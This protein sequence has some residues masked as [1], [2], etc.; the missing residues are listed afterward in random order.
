MLGL[1]LREEFRGARLRG[2]TIDFTNDAKTGALDMEAKDFLA[3]TY[4]SIDL[5]KSI[6]AV[7]PGSNRTVVLVGNRGQGKSHLMAALCHMLN[8]PIAGEAWLGAWAGRIGQPVLAGLSLRSKLHVIAEPLHEQ[9]FP[10]LW[11]ILFARHPKGE[12][13]KGKWQGMKTAVPG[14]DI[15]V[16]MFKQQPTA[17]LLDEFQTWF[18]GLN[19]A[20]EPRQVWAF[21]F[22]QLLS[23]IAETNPE[24]LALVVSVR[25][26]NSNAAQQLFR[27]NPVRVDFKGEQAQQDRRRLLLYRIFE[28]RIN[29]PSAQIDPIVATHLSEFMRLTGKSGSEMDR[30]KARFVE[31]WP[32]SPE[33]MQLLDDEVIFAVQA[34]GTRDL[35]RILVEL[36]KTAGEKVPVI[37]PADFD[38]SGD[39][40]GSAASLIDT[41]G[42]DHH[43]QLRDK[44][45]RNL[46]AVEE[47][48]GS[49]LSQVPHLR[50]IVSALWLRSLSLDN[51][52]VGAEPENL[53]ID[54]TRASKVD[55]NAFQVELQAIENNSYNIHKLG[56]RLMFKLEENARTRLLA[57]ARNDKIFQN[58]EDV[59][60]LATEIR[61]AIGGDAQVSGLYR[62]VVLKR[63]WNSTPWD[64]LEERERP[65]AWDGRIPVIVLPASPEFL[66]ATLGKWLMKFLS[67]ARNTP[68]F[69]LPRKGFEGTI[70]Q[71]RELM[72]LARAACLAKEWAKT[73]AAYRSLLVEFNNQIKAKIA[74]RFDRFAVLRTWNAE[75]ASKCSFDVEPHSSRGDKIPLAIQEKIK[76]NL[77]VAEEFDEMVVSL[78]QSNRSLAYLL[79]ELREP[80]GGGKECIP[81]LG[82][83]EAK[84]AVLAVCADGRVAVNVRGLRSLQR[85]PGEDAEIALRRMK[86]DFD[87]SGKQLENTLLTLPG[88]P[89]SSAGQPTAGDLTASG[90]TQTLPGIPES[91]TPTVQSGN[92]FEQVSPGGSPFSPVPAP[93]TTKLSSHPTSG[94]NLLSQVADTWCIGPAT[95]VR[96]VSIRIDKL[97]GAQLQQLIK[98]LPD[99]VVYGLDVDKEDA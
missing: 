10:Y 11:D 97:T 5:I 14:K 57:H 37:T 19:N 26:G 43:K 32:Y 89:P 24:L 75:D 59:D 73:E 74:D 22:I 25:E 52:R 4:P 1:Q 94:L 44:A 40:R 55:D 9:R 7:A 60:Y 76:Q 64:E 99:G 63:E 3:I 23:E 71:D 88:T 93:T 12:F 65:G 70:Y 61:H 33:L 6:K 79:N 47:A 2:T 48:L 29:I 30:H 56:S 77:F 81:W 35:V 80:R 41:V 84:D 95:T 96:N 62:T 91:S 46:T 28:N 42:I 92:P 21:N 27:V 82:E 50:E 78:A 31:A 87:V 69:L 38:L 58:G 83:A 39:D 90:G 8:D 51:Q 86:R 49:D 34:Q 67:S 16:E 98:N 85:V 20:Q 66:D 17:L 36:F 45:L 18:D 68:R 13:A 72:L 15:L 53:Q 54:V